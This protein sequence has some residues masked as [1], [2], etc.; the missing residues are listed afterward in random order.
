MIYTASKLAYKQYSDEE[1]IARIRDGEQPLYEILVRRYNPYLYKIS[2][3][4]GYSHEDSE[5]LMQNTYLNAFLHLQGYRSEASVK[6]WLTRIMLNQCYKAKH[7][8]EV[9]RSIASAHP[10]SSDIGGIP[11]QN[12]QNGEQKLLRKELGQL[13]ERAIQQIP[14]TYRMVFTLR[15]LN[16][17]NVAE[18]AVILGISENNVKVRLNRAKALIKENL[19]AHYAPDDIFE[20]N[21]MYCDAIVRRVLEKIL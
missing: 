7:T 19:Q 20:F 10:S 5:D 8:N 17:H 11:I 13:I 12:R 4:Y 14:E 6:T 15:E 2:R 21:E 16:H 18:T 9:T 3:S 1:I